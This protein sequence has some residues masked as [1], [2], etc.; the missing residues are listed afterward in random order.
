MLLGETLRKHPPTIPTDRIV[1]PEGF[2]I[3]VPLHPW[4]APEGIAKNYI[5]PVAEFPD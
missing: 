4:A 1:P 5:D 2:T 3:P